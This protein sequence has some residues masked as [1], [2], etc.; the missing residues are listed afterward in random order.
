MSVPTLL[1]ILVSMRKKL[2]AILWDLRFKV[3]GAKV[4]LLSH[5]SSP[6]NDFRRGFNLRSHLM[7]IIMPLEPS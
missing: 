6:Y 4:C 7:C 3:V 5:T 2:W 1:P